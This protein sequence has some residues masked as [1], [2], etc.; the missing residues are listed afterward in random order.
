VVEAGVQSGY[1]FGGLL[2][3]Y[4]IA[5]CLSQEELAQ[6]A[7]LSVRA[8]ADMERGRTARPYI[9][10]VRLLAEALGVPEPDRARLSAAAYGGE[11]EADAAAPQDT[12]SGRAQQSAT[13]RQLPASLAT[14]TGRTAELEQLSGLLNRVSGDGGGGGGGAAMIAVIDGMPGVGKTALAVQFA[15][16]AADRFRDGQ[17]HV[18]L[19]G[20]DSSGDP[21]SPEEAVRGFLDALGVPHEKIPTRL[22][23]QTALYRSLLADK[24][25]LVLLDNA[26]DERQVRPLLPTGPGCLTLVTSRRQLAGLAAADGARLLTLDVLSDDES[27]QLLTASLGTARVAADLEAARELIRLCARLPLAL[28]IAAAWAASR[29][30][31]PLAVITAELQDADCRLDAL[32]TGE[33]ACASVRAVFSWSYRNLSEPAARMFKL[34]GV[35]PGPDISRSAAASLAAVSRPQAGCL[36]RELTTAHLLTEE[37]PGRYALHDLLRIYAAEL[38]ATARGTTMRRAAV[39]RLLDHYLYTA[40]EA[41]RVLYPARDPLIQGSPQRGVAPENLDTHDAAMAWFDAE[42]EVLLAATAQAAAY[43]VGTYAWQIPWAMA[44][45]FARR[46]YWNEW[47][48]IQEVALVATR[49]SGDLVGQAQT[50]RYLARARIRL[51]HHRDANGHLMR[52]LDLYRQL[53]DPAGQALTHIDIAQACESRGDYRVA[54]GHARQALSLYEIAGHT[55]GRARA[56]NTLGLDHAH[57]GHHKQ[58]ISFCQQALSLHQEIGDRFGEAATLDSL[59]YAFRALG[60][61]TQAATCYQRAID[62]HRQLDDRFHQAETL[63][64]L[65]DTHRAAG[66]AA[67]ARQ[68]WAQALVILEDLKHVTADEVRAS[69]TSHD[70][71][72][73]RHAARLPQNQGAVGRH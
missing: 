67:E 14:F 10:S 43:N 42:R 49:R 37:L 26:R 68:V 52:V 50:H 4:R 71:P 18:N 5:A 9:R 15:H 1:Q 11:A 23:L 27:L 55:T 58:A 48:G 6:R 46:G 2:R 44:T 45:F 8:L 31:F 29:A 32:E 64:Y 34:L 7:G 30:A 60:L 35:H 41:D 61:H 54:I 66:R 65:G 28:S 51:G 63:R 25:M 39:R 40:L 21:V 59:G 12:G 36:L 24:R 38:T 47:A 22:D 70:I 72:A 53:G 69:L 62:L 57:L 20:F 73:A 17:L 16:Q 56:L 19:R 33:D 3:S 13:P